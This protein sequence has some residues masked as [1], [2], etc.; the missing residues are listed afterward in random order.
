[1]EQRRH[2]RRQGG[3]STRPTWWVLLAVSMAV[4]AL[5][6]SRS[7]G[8]PHKAGVSKSLER[9]GDRSRATAPNPTTPR[10]P[11]LVRAAPAPNVVPSSSNGA[12]SQSNDTGHQ[13]PSSAAP[14]SPTITT[15]T[16]TVESLQ[17]YLTYPDNVV[18][19]Y[20]IVATGREVIASATWSG[21]TTLDLSINCSGNQRSVSGTSTASVSIAA[22]SPCTVNL[23]DQGLS[24]TPVIF[25]LTITMSPAS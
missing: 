15:M 5:I 16:P 22:T 12:P 9:S 24:T 10:T 4:M 11:A 6:F 18:S 8:T 7:G 2:R 19:S 21:Q 25:D 13:P 1:M 17:G 23:T 20:P 3:A 14:T